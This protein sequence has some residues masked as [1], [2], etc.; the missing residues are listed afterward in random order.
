MLSK[1]LIRVIISSSLLVL[2]FLKS[3]LGDGQ[4]QSKLPVIAVSINPIY[5]IVLSITK[6]RQNTHLIINNTLSEHNYQMRP[7]D[8]VNINNADLVFYVSDDLETFMTKMAGNFSKQDQ[9]SQQKFWQLIM[10]SDLKILPQKSDTTKD[11]I[12]IWLNPD[13]AIKIAAFIAEKIIKLDPANATKYQSNLKKFIAETNATTNKVRN[14]I[15]QVKNYNY[16]VYHDGYVYFEDYF[17]IQEV[18]AIT[19]YEGQ[20]LTISDLK[21]I[22]ALIKSK[23]VKCIFGE[24]DEEEN[25]GLNIANNAKIKFAILNLIGDKKNYGLNKDGY[26]YILEKVGDDMYS[27][28]SN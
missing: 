2:V 25:T 6:D 4:I 1:F 21:Q 13:N 7:S 24:P 5:Q 11:D 18:M 10:V 16:M 26:N 22:M 9:K 23:D 27:C 19:S 17:G 15:N 8:V 12:H 3:A 14:Q 28:L 20:M